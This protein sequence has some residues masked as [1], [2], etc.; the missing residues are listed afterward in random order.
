MGGRVV[1]CLVR[2]LVLVGVVVVDEGVRLF[3][4]LLL[5]LVEDGVGVWGVW[6]YYVSLYVWSSV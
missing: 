6:V 3:L 1:R 2:L 5:L 4:G